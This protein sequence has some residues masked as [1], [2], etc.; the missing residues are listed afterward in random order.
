MRP[1]FPLVEVFLKSGFP[2]T[3]LSKS[4]LFQA[5]MLRPGWMR[6]CHLLFR[7]L[8]DLSITS[9]HAN[10]LSCYVEGDVNLYRTHNQRKRRTKA[11]KITSDLLCLSL[12]LN[13]TMLVDALSELRRW[14][15]F[16][17][18][19][20]CHCCRITLKN[21]ISLVLSLKEYEYIDNLCLSGLT[22]A[23]TVNV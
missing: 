10:W 3:M 1:A 15:I 4:H 22:W 11:N 13:A 23:T 9:Y 17:H 5:G 19:R 8:V 21:R 16:I 18:K 20:N 14:S 7:L 6:Q 2:Q 12:G